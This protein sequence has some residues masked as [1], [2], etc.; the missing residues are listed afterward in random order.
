MRDRRIEHTIEN[1]YRSSASDLMLTIGVVLLI[2]V[3]LAWPSLKA[4]FG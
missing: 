3:P 2:V 4:M 1:T